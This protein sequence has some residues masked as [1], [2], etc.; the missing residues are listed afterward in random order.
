MSRFN[1]QVTKCRNQNGINEESS[2]RLIKFCL[3][4]KLPKGWINGTS[5]FVL[6]NQ[7]ITFTLDML[8]K[9]VIREGDQLRYSNY[10]RAQSVGWGLV[11]WGVCG[12]NKTAGKS[13][14][15]FIVWNSNCLL[16]EVLSSSPNDKS[17]KF[18]A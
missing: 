18:V 15:Y 6:N 13:L 7:T 17:L 12:S 8:N 10:S 16:S 2:I 3:E 14:N 11:G 9:I 5:G 1:W 4:G